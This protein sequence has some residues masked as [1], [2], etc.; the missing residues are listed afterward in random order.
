MS[1]ETETEKKSDNDW[2]KRE[3]GALWRREGKSQNYLSGYVKFGEF[4][5]EK[6]VRVIVF[7]NKGK[8]KNPKAPDFVIYESQELNAESATTAT[9]IKAPAQEEHDSEVPAGL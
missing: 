8:S 7:T 5:T 4:G 9:A 2:S 6:E 3:M 1:T